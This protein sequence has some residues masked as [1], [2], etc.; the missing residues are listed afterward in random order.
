[1]YAYFNKY[2]VMKLVLQYNGFCQQSEIA[3]T[4]RM[5]TDAG[6]GEGYKMT[7]YDLCNPCYRPDIYLYLYFMDGRT[8]QCVKVNRFDSVFITK[9]EE[10]CASCALNQCE[11]FLTVCEID[12][13]FANPKYYR[14]TNSSTAGADSGIRRESLDV[15]KDVIIDDLYAGCLEPPLTNFGDYV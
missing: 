5:L 10:I 15:N 11:G 2:S 7:D 4:M 3:R 14:I 6:I 1:M 12:D 8:K 13:R 9:V